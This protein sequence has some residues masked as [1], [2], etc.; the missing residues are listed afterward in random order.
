GAVPMHLN[1]TDSD[2]AIG[3]TYK[4][5]NGGPGSPAL[6]WVNEKHRDQFWQCKFIFK[7]FEF[8]FLIPIQTLFTSNHLVLHLF[9]HFL[10]I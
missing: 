1:Q 2:F 7:F 4:Y 6:L 9:L 8:I 5:L 10:C 3:C